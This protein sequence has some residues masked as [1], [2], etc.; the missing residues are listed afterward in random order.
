M[1]PE[2]PMELICLAEMPVIPGGTT[3]FWLDW[4]GVWVPTDMIPEL[5]GSLFS[6]L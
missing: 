3:N 1:S 2:I 6:S 4:A 5:K